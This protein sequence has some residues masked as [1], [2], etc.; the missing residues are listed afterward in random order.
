MHEAQVVLRVALPP[1]RHP[2][3]A[4]EPRKEALYF[5]PATVA[6]EP[7]PVL[8]LRARPVPSVRCDQLDAPLGQSPVQRVAIVGPIAEKASR[9]IA[10]KA[11][12]KRRLNQR[13]LM[14]GS[15]CHVDGERK[16]CAVCDGHDLGPLAALG[17]PDARTPFFAGA[18]VA[19][20]A[21]S[22]RSRPPRRTRSSA[23]ALSARAR[24]PER[25]HVWKRRWHVAGEGYRSG[26]SCQRAPVLST[27]STP[28]STSRSGMRG[29]PRRAVGSASKMGART[30][31]CS[32]VSRIG[33]GRLVSAAS[34]TDF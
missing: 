15:A 17:L 2:A 22:E 1:H 24:S 4:Q 16:T 26:R 20:T 12:R 14:R 32:S 19:S 21:H 34:T 30:F 25:F 9:R 3:V 27:Q 18:K 10:R 13:R 6:S 31:H 8:R 23:R 33:R 29:R 11:G 5:P 28:S 7:A